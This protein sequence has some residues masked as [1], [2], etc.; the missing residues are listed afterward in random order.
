MTPYLNEQN[1]VSLPSSPASTNY[2]LTLTPTHIHVQRLSPRAGKQ[3][4]LILPLAELTGC[5]CPRSPAPPLLVLYWYPPGRRRKGVSRHRQVR[6]YLAESRFEA[7]KWNAAVQSLLRGM[8][9]KIDG[10]VMLPR[11]RRLLLLVNPFSGRGQAMQWC[12]THILPMIR[13]A[14][15]SYN[16]IQTERQN[17]ARELIKEISLPEWDGIVIV[18]GDGLL[19]EVNIVTVFDSFVTYI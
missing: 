15:V 1:G 13:E 8:D 12:Q 4:R 14:N 3:S 9:V 10:K 6:A 17:H 7:E 2:A 19:H 16:L 5:S 11:P 18:S